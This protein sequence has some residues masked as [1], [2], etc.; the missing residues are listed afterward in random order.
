M[1]VEDVLVI[2]LVGLFNFLDTKLIWGGDYQRTM[3]KTFGTILP[4]GTGGRNPISYDEDGIDNDKDGEIDE[5]DELLV[6]NEFGLYGQTQSK[7]NENFQ[8]I[9][10]GR[11]DLHSG[12]QTEGGFKFLDDPFSG[13]SIEYYPQIS[14]KI[15]LLYK[16][17]EN[18]TYR[19]T[20]I[21]CI[22]NYQICRSSSSFLNSK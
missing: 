7:L 4:D 9:L 20:C 21:S 15:G 10:S 5:W 3:P 18:Q 1:E 16:P 11:L 13:K 8:L 17:N 22:T 6:T 12:Q 19:L 2:L 14:P